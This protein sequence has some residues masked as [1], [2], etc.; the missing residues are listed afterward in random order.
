M[1]KSY[2]TPSVEV[3]KFEYCDQVVANSGGCEL[4]RNFEESNNMCSESWRSENGYY[5]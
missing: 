2:K 3:V 1:K 5:G 4:K